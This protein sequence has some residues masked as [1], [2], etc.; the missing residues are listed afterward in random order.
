MPL[1]EYPTVIPEKAGIHG[2]REDLAPTR[3]TFRRLCFILSV[4]MKEKLNVGVDIGGTKIDAVL[5]DDCGNI[6]KRELKETRASEGPNA[7]IKRI[8]DAVKA[9]SSGS[10]IAAV[11]IGA[12]GI[13]DVE[14]GLIT[15][16][17]NLPG[18]RNIKLKDILERELGIKT[19]VDNDATVAALAEHK[20]GIAAGCDHF[21]CVTLGTGIGGGIVT[22]GQVYR[23]TSGAAGEIGHMTIDVN[24][25]L[26]GC[27]NRGCWET[28]A[29][30]SALER[31]AKAK[32]AE[33]IQT[34]IPR[35]A[36][37]SDGRVTAKGIF[38]AAQDGD[39]L[40]KKLIE[41]LGFY[42]G[43]GL[44]NLINIF[45][46]QLVVISG[47]VSRM[48]DMLLE[49]ARKTVR[50]RAFELSAKAVRVEVSSLGYDAGPLGAVALALSELSR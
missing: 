16:S 50:E 31:E 42:V 47:G 28:L 26:C 1:R 9:V 21:I 29:S 11:G 33:G 20:F 40:A 25:P 46:P 19:F 22:N 30:G 17:P 8:V 14:T 43:V 45:N 13:I 15:T 32:M 4:I 12:A 39:E 18:W 6:I 41:Q 24:G 48:G 36:K 10:K 44:S 37:G 34:T 3:L 38:L 5:A 35:Y 27:G 2:G 49:P 23:G 7:V